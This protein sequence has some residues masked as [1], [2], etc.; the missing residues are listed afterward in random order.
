MGQPYSIIA[1][2]REEDYELEMRRSETLGLGNTRSFFLKRLHMRKQK[3]LQE[4]HYRHEQ[5][6]M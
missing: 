1:N 4:L 6:L 2:S 5:S 3:H